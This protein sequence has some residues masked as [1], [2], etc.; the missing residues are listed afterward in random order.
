MFTGGRI[1]IT[2]NPS[3]GKRMVMAVRTIPKKASSRASAWLQI[4]LQAL[5]VLASCAFLAAFVWIVVNRLTWPFENEWL[6]GDEFHHAW[7]IM[8]GLA[9]YPPP[10]VDFFPAFYTPGYPAVCAV[11]MKLFGESLTI[12][13][14][15][16]VVSTMT[17]LMLIGY[18]VYSH[19][20]SLFYP[21]VSC[22]VFMASF[23]AC[24]AWFDIARVDMLALAVALG[25]IALIGRRSRPSAFSSGAALLGLS[26]FFKQTNAALII[27][28]ILIWLIWDWRRG[29][30]MLTIIAGITASGVLALKWTSDGWYM[31]YT[32]KVP[33]SV[34]ILW[35][36]LWQFATSDI[37]SLAG[38]LLPVLAVGFWRIIAKQQMDILPVLLFPFALAVSVVP[39]LSPNGYDNLFVT[40]AAFIGI[41]T[42]LSLW[43]IASSKG[44]LSKYGWVALVLILLH[45]VFR[46]YDPSH[47][48]SHFRDLAK[49]M[50]VIEKIRNLPSPVLCP[51]HPYLLHLAGHPMHM[52]FNMANELQ[53]QERTRTEYKNL[54]SGIESLFEQGYWKSYV[55]TQLFQGQELFGGLS[56]FP[57]RTIVF[58]PGPQLLDPDDTTTLFPSTGTPVRPYRVY[59]DVHFP[60]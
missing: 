60:K 7:R 36:R 25:A 40:I 46:C 8:Q 52:T 13:R 4:I 30:K 21:V 17:I 10:S 38:C 1:G 33:G 9:W 39:R 2:Q 22:G 24:G 47:H 55:S 19:T 3:F 43:A 18:I 20:R 23:E 16:S 14:S 28:A 51:Y 37:L 15:V 26:Y 6:E 31:F 41:A 34:P 59:F 35:E 48:F 11:L 53:I 29:L 27:G 49:G 54:M 45:F 57:Q 44:T 56:N 58:P 32:F 50:A 5:L 12:M 42:G